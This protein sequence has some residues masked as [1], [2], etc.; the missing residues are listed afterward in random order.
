[1]YNGV[2]VETSSNPL[3]HVILRGALTESGE[4][5]PNY[6]YEDLMKV[7]HAY[8]ASQLKNPF[9][10]VDTNHDNSGKKYKN[11]HLMIILNMFL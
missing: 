10:M 2:E 11:K 8:Q 6:H 3:A 4:V 9:I 5:V 1:M 7:V